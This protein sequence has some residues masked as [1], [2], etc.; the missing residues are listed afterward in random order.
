[1]TKHYL[2]LM[3]IFFLLSWFC[4][5]GPMLF[6]FGRAFVVGDAVQKTTMGITFMIAA[7]LF[8]INVLMKSHLRSVLWVLLLGVFVVMNHY[9]AIIIVFAVTCFLDELIFSPLYR[10]YH[11][12]H[13]INKEIDKRKRIG[14]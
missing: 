12:L 7:V 10:R 5:L 8:G 1:M 9:L 2:K 14:E 11:T 4:V 3:I 6:F 13:T